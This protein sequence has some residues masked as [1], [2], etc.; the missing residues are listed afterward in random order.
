MHDVFICHASEDKEA[1]VRPLAQLLA[2]VGLDV[3]YDEFSLRLGDSLRES[4]DRGLA[5]SNYGVVV[6]SPHF[7]AKRWPQQELNGLFAKEV[8][9][10]KVILPVWHEITREQI[11]GH[12]PILADRLGVPTRLGIDVVAKQILNVVRP[13]L[14]REIEET[15]QLRQQ[16]H[17]IVN[18]LFSFLAERGNTEPHVQ[19]SEVARSC[20]QS[21]SMARL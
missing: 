16:L 9:G 4:I 6:L 12:S 13:E 11:L 2:N 20:R 10:D 5:Q 1:I 15:E 7:F 21:G 17:S 19:R 8:G 3:W 14:L 18:D